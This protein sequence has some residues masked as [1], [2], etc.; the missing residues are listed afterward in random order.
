[1]LTRDNGTKVL[2]GSFVVRFLAHA[3]A[4]L[5]PGGLLED[6]KSEAPNFYRWASAVAV[7]PSV[8][9]IFDPEVAVSGAKRRIAKARA[10][11]VAGS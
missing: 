7:H 5:L 9:G 6:V 11:G 10:T 3:N 2:T 8:T 1:M 4:G